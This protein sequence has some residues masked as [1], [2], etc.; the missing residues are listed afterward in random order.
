MFYFCTMAKKRKAPARKSKR[1]RPPQSTLGCA[2]C[3][4]ELESFEKPHLINLFAS[5]VPGGDL[6]G[7]ARLV[8]EAPTHVSEANGRVTYQNDF[9]YQ[10]TACEALWLQQ[11][12]EVD[13]PETAMEEF[14]HRYQRILPLSS[15]QVALI[16]A[17][18]RSGR[19]LAHNQFM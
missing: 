1:S 4:H 16:R 7:L 11:Y 8:I 15:R 3:S 9:V 13:T 14:G 5:N 12:W 10:C 6:S 19:K 18:V 17:A 2:V